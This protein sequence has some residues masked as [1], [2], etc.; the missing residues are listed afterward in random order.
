[1]H[2]SR[3]KAG[4]RV[5]IL[6]LISW[7]VIAVGL[8]LTGPATAEPVIDA[9]SVNGPAC[10][11]STTEGRD[12][13]TGL[14][15]LMSCPLPPKPITGGVVVLLEPPGED[16]SNITDSSLL[17]AIRLMPTDPRFTRVSDV[18]LIR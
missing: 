6:G 5:V 3:M 16:N 18:F 15:P 1:M 14:S 11:F 17:R 12:E 4:R 10:A 13:F 7:C 8:I 2:I 9:F